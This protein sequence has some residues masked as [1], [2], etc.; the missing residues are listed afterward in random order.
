MVS[1]RCTTINDSPSSALHS[2]S[3]PPSRYHIPPHPL[4]SFEK[5]SH[6]HVVS[7]YNEEITGLVVAFV[8]VFLVS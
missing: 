6:M 7:P 2:N 4:A 5:F 8:V 3:K 1:L